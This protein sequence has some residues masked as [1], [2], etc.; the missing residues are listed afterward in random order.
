M[1]N[2]GRYDPSEDRFRD[3]GD[4][5]YGA[6]Q[7]EAFE[8]FEWKSHEIERVDLETFER[9]PEFARR[10]KKKRRKKNYLLRFVILCLIV[11]GGYLFFS[12]DRFDIKTI[13]VNGNSHLTSKRIIEVSDVKK[14]DNIVVLRRGEVAG[15]LMKNSYVKDCKVSKAYPDKLVIDVTE[16]TYAGIIPYGDRYALI[17][18][19]GILISVREERPDVTMIDGVKIKKMRAREEVEVDKPETLKQSLEFLDIMR[20][21]DLVFRSI[22]VREDG[23][24]RIQVY[25]KLKAEGK[26][27]TIKKHMKNGN[28]K[29]LLNDLQQ[30]DRQTGSLRFIDERFCSYN[31]KYE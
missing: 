11:G 10:R 29:L 18:P 12:S 25:K 23:T 31:P 6:D 7:D 14:G 8:E 26:V 3:L 27:S 13:E 4:E 16:R 21:G 9:D 17:D 19:E 24:M 5:E 15:R 30:K 1:K 20:E 22:Y 2:E 28:F